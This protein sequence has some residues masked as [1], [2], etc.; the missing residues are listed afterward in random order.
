MKK[1]FTLIEI[2][3][4]I[5]ILGVIGLIVVNQA[6]DVIREVRINSL[7]ISANKLVR[8]A[9]LYASQY[10]EE[11]IRKFQIIDGDLI[12]TERNTIEYTGKITNAVITIDSNSQVIICVT[13]GKNSAYKNAYESKVTVVEGQ[14]CNV[15]KIDVDLDQDVN[16]ES[17]PEQ[18]E[19]ENT[20][21]NPTIQV[22][23]EES[24]KDYDAAYDTVSSMKSSKLTVGQ[25]IKT[26]GFYNKNDGGGAYYKIDNDSSS[27]V[28]SSTVIALNN[29]LKAKLIKQDKLNLKQ[30]GAK[31]D[32]VSDDTS[33]INIA[34]KFMS[35]RTLYIPTGTY[36]VSSAITPYS[37]STIIGDGVGSLFKAVP[38]MNVSS[39]MFKMRGKSNIIVK[40]IGISGNS[41][42]NTRDTGHSATDGI[43]M[44]DIWDSSNIN[45]DEVSFI[46][47]IY[48]AIRI[49]GARSIHVTNSK[50]LNIDC[51]VIT[52]GSSDVTD[53]VIENNYFDGHQNSEPISLYGTGTY[54]DIYINNNTIKNK[55]FGNAMYL[56]RGTIINITV[57]N[58]I[59][60]DC[61]TGIVLG[62]ATNATIKNNDID[63]SNNLS[64]GGA[65]ISIYSCTNVE[66][67]NNRIR[68][69]SQDC[70]IVRNNTSV[71]IYNNDIRDCGNK[72]D[73]FYFVRFDKSNTDVVFHD[74]T[75]VREDNNLHRILITCSGK[76]STKII[77]NNLQNGI[78]YL[79]P[80]SE[81]YIIKNNNGVSVT[82]KGTNNT[83][84]P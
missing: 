81:D 42:Y 24:K 72:N 11:R 30:F 60:R 68:K 12:T 74:N 25:T 41:E 76:Q 70:L 79:W 20:T 66:I 44:F 54:R 43:H 18:K 52:L 80:E 14:V 13:D 4:T 39:D 31:G 36:M 65:G 50:F 38:G 5:I 7:R 69:V 32:G 82:N 75:V 40:R 55:S 8:A 63:N 15:D 56:A 64:S 28:D 45:V 9:N 78:I 19:Q 21:T 16:I 35:G 37:N 33:I 23:L 22:V 61:A 1:R 27:T 34:F 62:N 3:V 29:G 73:N 47:N 59:I 17:Q 53:L 77:N 26:K 2:V 58:N 49:V 71:N 46:D 6:D 48:A 83:I 51:G 84:E 57:T 10:K 67:S